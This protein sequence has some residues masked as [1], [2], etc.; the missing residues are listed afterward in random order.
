VPLYL[1]VAVLCPGGR[2]VV[3]D[4]RRIGTRGQPTTIL[5]PMLEPRKVGTPLAGK[6]GPVARMACSGHRSDGSSRAPLGRNL[7]R[8]DDRDRP[9]LGLCRRLPLEEGHVAL[10]EVAGIRPR[11]TRDLIWGWPPCRIP[12]RAEGSAVEL[13]L[14]S[15]RRTALVLVSM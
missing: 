8:D 1:P 4:Q 7:R 6:N 15:S 14:H 11:R 13:F 3:I 5:G 10:W 2:F 12:R 9:R